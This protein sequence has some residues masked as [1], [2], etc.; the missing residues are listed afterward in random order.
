MKETVNGSL[1][2]PSLQLLNGEYFGRQRH[3]NRLQ[4][5]QDKDPGFPIKNVGNDGKRSLIGQE[6]TGNL[7]PR[8]RGRRYGCLMFLAGQ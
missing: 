7:D 5:D 2:F 8:L 3:G 6:L 1:S 4:H